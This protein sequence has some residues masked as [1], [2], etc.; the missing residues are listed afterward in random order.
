M[1]VASW[2]GGSLQRLGRERCEPAA[3]LGAALPALAGWGWGGEGRRRALSSSVVMN[4][5]DV[6]VTDLRVF[7]GFKCLEG[8]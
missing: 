2:E 8:F 7:Q 3:L 6:T 1:V 5:Q 4:K